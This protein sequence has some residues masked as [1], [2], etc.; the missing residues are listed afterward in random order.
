MRILAVD[1]WLKAP[2]D[3]DI[4]TRWTVGAKGSGSHALD[5]PTPTD[6]DRF[7]FLALGDTGDS[8]VAGSHLS[9]QDAVAQQMALDAALP[10]GP[11][12][13]SLIL[14]MG[15]VIYMTGERRLYDRNFRRPYAPF[16]TPESTVDQLTFRIPFLPVPGN[17]DYY[18]L[19][20]W[21]KWIGRF[22]FLGAGIQAIA[23]QLFAFNL[24]KGGS[25]MGRAYMKAFVDLKADTTT[26]PLPYVPGRST[27]LPNR[28]YRYRYGSVDFFALD[29][30]TL[31]APPPGADRGAVRIEAEQKIE[32]LEATARDIDTKLRRDQKA[33]DR[34]RNEQRE[35][36]ARDT[37]RLT[38]FVRELPAVETALRE[39]EQAL[40]EVDPP[41][42]PCDEARG[43]ITTARRR[44]N[45]ATE[46]FS[47]ADGTEATVAALHA[48]EE[49][50]D[51]GYVALSTLEEC[52]GALSEGVVRTA[53]LSAREALELS[54]QRCAEIA[55][56]TPADLCAHMKRLSEDALDVQR[57]LAVERRRLRFR[58]EDH[59]SAQ[60]E[61]LDRSLAE[62]VKERPGGWR[63]VYLHHP[64][65]TSIRNHSEKHNVQDVRANLLDLLKGRVHLVLSGHAHAFEWFRSSALP[66]AGL[67][68][69]GGG[70]QISLR[71]SLLD[72]RLLYRY[73]DRYDSLRE[74]GAGECAVGGYGPPAP[75]G[76]AGNTYHYLKIEVTTEALVVQPIGVRRLGDGT[77]RRET[78][79][80][81]YHAP[82]LPETRPPWEPRSLE[83]VEVRR[84]APPCPVWGE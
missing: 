72:P 60:L 76:E 53:L 24:P 65:Y 19:G 15:D 40:S 39:L 49:A 38:A 57:D 1:N 77:Y 17:H 43:A 27:R 34:W 16:L 71:P 59:D 12:D 56:P 67:F 7:T 84:D 30:N 61:W 83:G 9:P 20:A 42:G 4:I 41:C 45:E 78:P 44:W 28:Y 80:R 82:E 75:D 48:L 50:S 25:D 2:A 69:T 14:H 32:A 64:L 70:G 18:D 29:S 36:T 10:D 21:M 26:A 68:V 6:P 8:E 55:V 58:P 51:E 11:G 63:V 33:L 81:V 23:H 35:A 37:S 52:L 47:A 54:L 22:P 66:H 31:D 79:M 5:L 13:A 62:A 73:R 74:H 46:D 3:R